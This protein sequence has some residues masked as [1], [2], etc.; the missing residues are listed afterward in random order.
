M[1]LKTRKIMTE[2]LSVIGY[3]NQ[4]DIKLKIYDIFNIPTRKN[5]ENVIR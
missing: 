2:I 4:F 3:F 5:S 1:S